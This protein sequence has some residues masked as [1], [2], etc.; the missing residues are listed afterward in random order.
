M[1]L[2]DEFLQEL[3][4]TTE[5]DSVL[6]LHIGEK[7]ESY[8]LYGEYFDSATKQWQLVDFPKDR[9]Q[10]LT[11]LLD[12][13]IKDFV[14]AMAGKNDRLK[15]LHNPCNASFISKEEQEKILSQ[16]KVSAVVTVN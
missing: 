1:N 7:S 14:A 15:S 13:C 6:R 8:R 3:V 12:Q 4:I 9:K 2:G 16:Q 11:P 5:N 10:E